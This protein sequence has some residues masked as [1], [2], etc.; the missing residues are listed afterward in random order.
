MMLASPTK[1]D[2]RFH[3]SGFLS[4][5]GHPTSTQVI[6]TST[7]TNPNATHGM[8]RLAT[9]R[10]ELELSWGTQGHLHC[11]SNDDDSPMSNGR[12]KRRK[13]VES[14]HSNGG[15]MMEGSFVARKRITPRSGQS[16]QQAAA[17]PQVKAGW[18]EGE[19]DAL[20]NRHGRGTTKHDDGTEYEG[21]YFEDVM[22][23]PCGCYKFLTTRCLVPNPH[24]NGSHLHRQTEKSFRGSF[25]DDVPDGAGMI[26]TQTTDCVPQVLGSTPVDV[27][28]RQVMYD[29]G[30]HTS[31]LSGKAA[32]EGVRIIYT[33]TI[34]GGSSSTLE[35]TCFRLMNGEN[36]NTQVAPAYAEWLLQCLDLEYPSPSSPVWERI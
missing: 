6:G 12:N 35:K 24:E 27:R 5:G 14:N 16:E 19:V 26:V 21:A 23:G 2:A 32:G 31:R 9:C 25:K 18:Y 17:R 11:V 33:T 20:G 3:S 8:K 13:T 34:F 1:E 15:S 10:E 30:M 22:E 7:A 29:A 28:F 4:A 36:T